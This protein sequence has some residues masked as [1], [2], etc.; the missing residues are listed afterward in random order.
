MIGLKA[1]SVAAAEPRSVA[2]ERRFPVSRAGTAPT[3]PLLLWNTT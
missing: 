1:K 3:P 2:K